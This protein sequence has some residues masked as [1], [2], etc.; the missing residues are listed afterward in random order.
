MYESLLVN[1]CFFILLFCCLYGA[2]CYTQLIH[3]LILSLGED[4][5]TKRETQISPVLCKKRHVQAHVHLMTLRIAQV[6]VRA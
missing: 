4:T 6:L 2:D 3:Y 1:H 5:H